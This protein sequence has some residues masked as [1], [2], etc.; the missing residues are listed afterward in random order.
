MQ[1]LRQKYDLKPLVIHANYLINLAGN[2]N[3]FHHKSITA[4]RG[5]LERAVA[6]GAEY[7]VVHAGAHRGSTRQEGLQRMAEAVAQSVEGCELTDTGLT[8]LIEN[9][10]GSEY[11]LG[12]SFEHLAELT[13][14]LRPIVP[15]AVCIDTCH[16]HVS[17]YDLVSKEGY[18]LTLR[19][20]EATIGLREVRVWHCN[21]AKAERGSGLDR[22]QHIGKGK[23]GIETFRRLLNDSR[24]AHAAFIAETPIDRPGD[25]LRNVEA[26]KSCVEEKHT[27]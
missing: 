11:S 26:L 2:N 17:G 5:E 9:T 8:I 1:E 23:L 21:D 20:L 3:E 18:D 15:V 22:H 13:E 6:L 14:R 24:L 16:T 12:G 7:L 25:D 27:G 10:A 19:H 4:F